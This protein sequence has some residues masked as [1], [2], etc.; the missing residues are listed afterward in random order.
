LVLSL[1]LS[2]CTLPSQTADK[3]ST[4]SEG[5]SLP[6]TTEKVEESE[7]APM[8]NAEADTQPDQETQETVE[9][10]VIAQQPVIPG[11]ANNTIGLILN[12]DEAYQGYT[13]FAPKHN[14]MTYL[15]DNNGQVVHSWT[16]SQYEP[17]QSV[18]LLENG[19]LLR[20]CMTRGQLS[21]GGGEGGRI[22]EY[23]WDGNLVWE[24]DFS[25]DQYMQH[26]DIE[27]LPNGNILLLAIE[28]KTYDEVVV[29]GFD[30]NNLNR[31][32]L[33]NRQMVPDAVYEIKPTYPSGG[34]IV[35]EW[36]T[37]DHLVQD[38]DPSKANYGD[39]SAHP[40][41][42]ATDGDGRELRMFWNH[43]NS[44]DYNVELD[45]IMLSVRGNNEIWVIDHSTT[46]A[47]ATSH[48]GGRYG[49]GGDLLYR[50]GNPSTYEAGNANSQTLYEQHDSQWIEAGSPG[51]GN[52]LVFNNGPKRPGGDY[53][54]IDEF[55]SPVNSDGSYADLSSGSAYSPTSAIWAYS[56]ADPTDLFSEAISGAQR[57]PNGNTLICDGVHG[58]LFEVSPFGEIVWKYINPVVD[59][60]AL[61]Q[62]E[63][64]SL[65]VRN[66]S[67]NAVFKIHRYS[68]DYPG[69]VGRDLTPQ[70]TIEN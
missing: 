55:V 36:H 50:W 65:D 63:V 64:P 19:H 58:V 57:L 22:E 16:A 66:H 47:E 24:L 41:L 45:Q 15:M 61:S 69:L 46:S 10:Q 20:A 43:M 34:E 14:T 33:E 67:Y 12:T 51:E 17:G 5:N 35:W 9:E 7:S 2:A 13:L 28:K 40:E 25:T 52:I 31:Q 39:I 4:Q 70:G 44:I 49:I 38:F 42:V 54:S 27:P 6:L 23:D 59:T 3:P 37:W 18:Y 30:P 68:L 21:T 26:H 29:A 53:S 1:V 32:I 60:G 11:D 56:A 62:G 48:A 8:Q